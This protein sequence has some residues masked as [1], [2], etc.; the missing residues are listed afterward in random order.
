[1]GLRAQLLIVSLLTLAL[2]WAGCQYVREMESALRTDHEAAL[3]DTALALARVVG[4]RPEL[5]YPTGAGLDPGHDYS[6]DLFAH[7]LAGQIVI[8]GYADD[9]GAA[10]DGPL[11]YPT[12]DG[13]SASLAVDAVAG[14]DQ[15]YAY[16]FVMVA[17]DVVRYVDD[18]RGPLHDRLLLRTWGDDNVAHEFVMQTRAPGPMQAQVQMPVSYRAAPAIRL[19]PPISSR[20]WVTGCCLW[21]TNPP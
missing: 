18:S 11:R 5:L 16:L 4:D 10:A 13:D 7:P 8:D 17:D 12:R 1:M 2:P 14:Y 21:W 3:Y 15:R 9:W 19:P 6:A 20:P